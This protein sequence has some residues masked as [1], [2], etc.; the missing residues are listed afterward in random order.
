MLTKG[1]TIL[2]VVSDYPKT[3]DIFRTYDDIA[4]KC[5]LFHNL[6]EKLEEFALMYD[7]NELL[8]HNYY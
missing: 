3:E 8:D 5:I 2:D 7:I 1:M 4:G 6:F